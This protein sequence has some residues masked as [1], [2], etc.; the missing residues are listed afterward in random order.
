MAGTPTPAVPQFFID[1]EPH[2]PPERMVKAFCD[3]QGL[4]IDQLGVRPVVVATFF[5]QLTGILAEQT[6][7]VPSPYK[8]AGGLAGELYVLDDRVTIATLRMGAPAA[9]MAC[10][11]LIACGAR[12]LLAVGAAGGVQQDVPIGS[13]VLAASAIREEGTSH[14]YLPAEVPATATSELL[15]ELREACERRGLAPRTGLH[16]STDAPY[17]EHLEKIAAYR[18]AGVLAVDMEISALYVLAQ[19]RGIEC[20][21]VLAVSDELYEP[22][23]IGFTAPQFLTAVRDAGLAAIDVAKA[24]A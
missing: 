19:T 14:H 4:T 13:V 20:A 1:G 11:E 15:E 5:S 18:H 21:A 9:V 8:L 22:W 6:G 12:T 24:R 23:R 7:A 16:W 2:L 3:I 17:R 10:E